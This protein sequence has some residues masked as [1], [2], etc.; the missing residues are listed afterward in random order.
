MQVRTDDGAVID[1]I[2]R[3]DGFL[4]KAKG[5]MF[6]EEGRALLVFSRSDRHA[7]WMPFMRFSL[8]VAFIDR[9]GRVVHTEEVVPPLSLDPSTWRRYGPPRPCRSILE[10][11]SGLFEEKGIE[12]GTELSF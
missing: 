5:L 1:D 6:K 4:E 9:D 7:I 8:D 12:T 3:L 11:E 10:V 2:E